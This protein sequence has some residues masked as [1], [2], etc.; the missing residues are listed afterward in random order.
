MAAAGYSWAW[1][2]QTGIIRRFNELEIILGGP[3]GRVATL[4]HFFALLHS[5]Y[6]FIV[7]YVVFFFLFYCFLRFGLYCFTIHTL[8]MW[9]D[10]WW[11]ALRRLNESGAYAMSMRAKMSAK[12]DEFWSD[13][14]AK[15]VIKSL[16]LAVYVY[17]RNLNIN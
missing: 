14:L 17:D 2:R 3:R 9:R 4:Q 13:F 5:R 6:L 1:A 10:V 12:L 16:A 7:A 11:L 15:K 8:S